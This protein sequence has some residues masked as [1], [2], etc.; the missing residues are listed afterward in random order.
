MFVFLD[1][2]A[3]YLSFDCPRNQWKQWEDFSKQTFYPC[4][5]LCHAHELKHYFADW[6]CLFQVWE[7]KVLVFERRKLWLNALQYLFV[8][9]S[10]FFAVSVRLL[11]CHD[12]SAAPNSACLLTG[13]R[14]CFRR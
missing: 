11:E 10:S 14:G 2:I 9:L 7:S 4:D 13:S 3:A 12:W 6:Y 8:P 5:T 1:Y